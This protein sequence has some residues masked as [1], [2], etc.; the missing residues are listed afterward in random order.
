MNDVPDIEASTATQMAALIERFA[1]RYAADGYD[2][3]RVA[4]AVVTARGF[5]GAEAAAFADE[6]GIGA[7]SLDDAERGLVALTDLPAPLR[8]LLRS[9]DL[10][11]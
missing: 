3:P 10:E 7:S 8:D 9:L 2:H 4:A 11:P 1:R 6:L 5:S